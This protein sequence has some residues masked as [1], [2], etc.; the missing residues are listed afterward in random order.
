MN[1][2]KLVTRTDYLL[3]Q[4]LDELHEQSREWLETIAFWKDET[5]FF[6]SLLKRH[7]Y[8]VPKEEGYTR[9][10]KNLDRLHEMLFD[11]MADEILAHERLLSR[12]E[13]GEPGLADADYRDPHR[14]LGEKMRVFESDFREFKKMVFGYARKW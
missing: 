9:L 2:K 1:T 4:G 5:R 11:Y 10:L 12:I 3:P 13:K 7:Q 8:E 14:R 6:S